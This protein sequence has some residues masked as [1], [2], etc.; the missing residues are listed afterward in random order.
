MLKAKS[1]TPAI[2]LTMLPVTFVAGQTSGSQNQGYLDSIK[3]EYR[4]YFGFNDNNISCF[5]VDTLGHYVKFTGTLDKAYA[6]NGT[7]YNFMNILIRFHIQ[8]LTAGSNV[9]DKFK[10]TTFIKNEVVKLLNI[11]YPDQLNT[12]LP[13]DNEI[14]TQVKFNPDAD[15]YYFIT[16]GKRF[17]AITGEVKQINTVLYFYI[18]M[19]RTG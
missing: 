10:D 5:Q 9:T 15:K 11:F 13:P 1:F 2:L 16:G 14:K 7:Y 3:A 4:T 18:E 8:R 12:S 6:F 19:S 17:D